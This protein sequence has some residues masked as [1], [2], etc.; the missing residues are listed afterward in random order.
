MITEP[1]PLAA[2]L[3]EFTG[4]AELADGRRHE[5]VRTG[6]R[7]PIPLMLRTLVWLRDGGRCC[8]CG[9]DDR[10]LMQLDHI[11]PWSAGGEDVATNL[12]VMCGPCNEARSNY[13]E[14]IPA[15][16]CLPVT[17]M[18]DWC[19]TRH[20]QMRSY[21]QRKRH[22]L[23]MSKA[24][25]GCPVCGDSVRIDEWDPPARAWCG[26]CG[27]LAVVTGPGRML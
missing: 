7:D 8:E 20:D 27:H 25:I 19:V 1:H 16:A 22:A 23:L 10:R 11:V 12:R 17:P 24:P 9:V 5:V 15:R 4:Q 13:V 26:S 21:R 2:L 14:I 3:A 6:E 18:C